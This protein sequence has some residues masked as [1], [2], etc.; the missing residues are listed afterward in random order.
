MPATE[1]NQDPPSNASPDWPLRRLMKVWGHTPVPVTMMS[2]K[3][4]RDRAIPIHGLRAGR[5]QRSATVSATSPGCN[6]SG[7]KRG[8]QRSPAPA[9]GAI[10]APVG[11][12]QVGLPRLGPGQTLRRVH[13]LGPSVRRETRQAGVHDGAAV[14]S[15]P[16]GHPARR[17][18]AR[19]RWPA[20]RDEGPGSLTPPPTNNNSNGGCLLVRAHTPV[21][22]SRREF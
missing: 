19:R 6:A 10:S 20:R 15:L 8:C 16:P 11:V 17:T 5:R 1:R 2:R 21:W 7:R 14:T 3:L 18:S 12:I 9:V 13:P 4:S 22:L